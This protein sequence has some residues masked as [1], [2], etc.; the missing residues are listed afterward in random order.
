[1]IPSTWLNKGIGMTRLIENQ[2]H[3]AT[4]VREQT[5]DLDLAVAFWGKGAIQML[6]LAK[7]GR[8]L[9]VLLDLSSGASHPDEVN[10]LRDLPRCK[11]KCLPRFHAKTYLSDT[12]IVVGSANA[13]ADGLGKGGTEHTRWHELAMHSEDPKVVSEGADWFDR[14]WRAA[15][16]VTA[17]DVATAK[18]KWLFKQKQRPVPASSGKDLLTAAIENPEAYR[19]LGLN[20]AV[21]LQDISD[22]GQATLELIGKEIGHVVYAFEDWSNIPTQ[23]KILSFLKY[24]G[25]DFVIDGV[26]YSG[27]KQ[28][29][30]LKMVLA[31]NVPGYKLGSITRWKK[32][33]QRAEDSDPKAWVRNGG[34]CMDLGDFAEQFGKE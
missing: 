5:G 29:T 21:A 26:Y 23:Q 27:E 16:K 25:E 17:E 9:R 19:H 13:S 24:E 14:K 33:L 22:E 6:G 34:I 20:V 8:D 1:M 18:V 28:R 30:R 2:Q 11:V 32:C 15:K 7:S 4:W 31:S 3:L 10:A 12:E